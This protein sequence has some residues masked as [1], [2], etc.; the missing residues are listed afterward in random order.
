MRK[1]GELLLVP[2]KQYALNLNPVDKYQFAGKSDRW[3]RFVNFVY[4]QLLTWE[5]D[6]YLFIEISEPTTAKQ[7]DLGPRLHLHGTIEFEN[8]KQVFD[9]LLNKMYQ[10]TRWCRVH[11]DTIED[12]ETW[13]NY[14]TKQQGIVPKNSILSRK[15]LFK[16]RAKPKKSKGLYKFVKLNASEQKSDSDEAE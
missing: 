9:F 2:K 14:C 13:M 8:N 6:Y 1:K 11:I 10:L 16:K 12:M 5:Y 15:M 4:E 7:G 3:N